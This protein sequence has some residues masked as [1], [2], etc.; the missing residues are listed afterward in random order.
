MRV[1]LFCAIYDLAML[2]WRVLRLGRG[3]VSLAKEQIA[4]VVVHGEAAR[5]VAVLGQHSAN[6]FLTFPESSDF[7]NVD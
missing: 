1:L 5:T 2:V 7:Q 3:F 4:N 6:S